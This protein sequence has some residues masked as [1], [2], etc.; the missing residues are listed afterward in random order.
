VAV[1][2]GY[3]DAAEELYTFMDAANVDLKAFT[4]EFYKAAV[5]R[6]SRRRTRDVRVFEAQDEGLVRDHNAADPGSE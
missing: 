3:I 6:P 2:A 5:H 1:T 4:E